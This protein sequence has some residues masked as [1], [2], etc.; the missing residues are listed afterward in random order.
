[1]ALTKVTNDMLVGPLGSGG[2]VVNLIT[3]GD[4]ENATSSIFTLYSD[5][6]SPSRPTDGTGGVPNITTSITST[7]PLT[8]NKSYL[9]TKAA[10]NRQGDGGA[11]TFSVDPSYR[12]KVLKISVD[13]IVNSGTFVA[14]SSSADSDV[15]WYLYDITNSQLIE[16][17]NIKMFSNSTT[18]SDKFEATFQTSATGSSYRLIAHVATTSASAWE[19]K[20]DNVT[21]SPSVYVYGTPITDW[22]S[23][24]PTG[25]WTTN[26]TYTGKKRRV[27]DEYE[28]MVRVATSGAPT[29]AAMIIQIQETIDTTKLN[30]TTQYSTAFESSGQ[31]YDSGTGH[32]VKVVYSSNPNQVAL[33]T[34]VG[35]QSL[36]G[37]TT[38][39]TFGAGDEINV[40][41]TLPILGK[42]ASVQM[43][44]GFEGR[45]IG[46]EVLRS[47]A[48]GSQAITATTQKIIFG[49]KT[50]DT[51]NS[52]DTT[53]SRY[54][55]L[56]AGDY[57]FTPRLSFNTIGA[58]GQADLLLYKNGSI[59]KTLTSGFTTAGGNHNLTTTFKD[60][61][62]KA[63]DYFEIFVSSS[64]T[65]Q[66]LSAA[67][68]VGGSR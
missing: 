3:D 15:I 59:Y 20:L 22:V 25:S 42:S 29:A 4:A 50:Q 52:F 57:E 18:I 30:T 28:Y 44:D 34:V 66:M 39:F 61:N 40:R 24:T 47:A 7:N 27:G 11:I 63:G 38:P 17:S 58:N 23:W 36:V 19:L 14:G 53:L 32:G 64:T 67:T 21:V 60:E 65:M 31:A 45:N 1:M 26:T 2:G 46:A 48:Q 13:Y 56:S 33:T 10:G 12:A 55:I 43:S 37:N 51:V 41:F 9:L 49:D 5:A 8:G 68:I 16:P 54:T 6:G 35:P 62:C